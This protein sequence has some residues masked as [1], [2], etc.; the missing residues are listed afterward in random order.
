MLAEELID[1]MLG[2]RGRPSSQGVSKEDNML[3]SRNRPS[4]QGVSK[5]DNMAALTM[6]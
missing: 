4:S 2:S 6:W 1:N 3:G 5:E